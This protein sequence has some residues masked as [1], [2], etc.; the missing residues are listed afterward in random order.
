MKARLYLAGHFVGEAKL[1]WPADADAEMSEP[2]AGM[3]VVLA[4]VA[5]HPAPGS[6][7][8]FVNGKLEH[9]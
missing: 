4:V 7:P 5:E 1:E 9:A 8:L 3:S 6:R 2:Y